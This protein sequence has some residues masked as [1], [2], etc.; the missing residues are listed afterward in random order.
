MAGDW[1]D[2]QNDAIVSICFAMFAHDIAGR[3]YSKA[4]HN[5]LR[6]AVIAQLDRTYA[7]QHQ[8]RAQETR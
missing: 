2:G 8:R 6:Q 7:P 5:R 1:S 4:E 3:P